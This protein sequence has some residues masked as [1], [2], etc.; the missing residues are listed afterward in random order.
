MHHC[1]S[2]IQPAS[3]LGTPMYKRIRAPPSAPLIEM[4]L[5]LSFIVWLLLAGTAAC[6]VPDVDRLDRHVSELRY[7][8]QQA[9]WD[10]TEELLSRIDDDFQYVKLNHPVSLDHKFEDTLYELEMKTAVLDQSK[11]L[12]TWEKLAQL[13]DRLH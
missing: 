4:R 5:S 3:A 13:T 7:T 8:I 9:R 6:G 11:A 12:K 1:G 10:E 2:K